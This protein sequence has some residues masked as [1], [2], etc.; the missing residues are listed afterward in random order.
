MSH[1]L[2]FACIEQ[3]HVELLPARTV[4]STFAAKGNGGDK[5]SGLGEAVLTMLGMT[6][7]GQST[8]GHDGQAGHGDS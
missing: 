6:Q 8:P 4:L 2:T 1:I 5:G 7:G 3:Q